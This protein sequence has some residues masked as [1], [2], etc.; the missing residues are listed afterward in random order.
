MYHAHTQKKRE[1][2][3]TPRRFPTLSIVCRVLI[4][5]SSNLLRFESVLSSSTS[6]AHQQ[7]KPTN[8]R[9]QLERNSSPAV[10]RKLS[11]IASPPTCAARPTALSRRTCASGDGHRRAQSAPTCCSVES[12]AA[13]APATKHKRRETN[14]WNVGWGSW[15]SC[16]CYRAWPSRASRY[17]QTGTRKHTQTSHLRTNGW[18]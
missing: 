3:L 5:A 9:K 6:P 4:D 1:T 16:P 14:A 10:A 7:H 15:C 8:S 18:V 12:F 2:N 11:R 13:G 17:P